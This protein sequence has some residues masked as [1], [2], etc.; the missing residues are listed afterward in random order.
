MRIFLGLDI[1]ASA[2]TELTKIARSW[3]TFKLVKPE[4]YHFT[5]VFLGDVSGD[6][7]SQITEISQSV[8]EKT[9]SF[10]ITLDTLVTKRD[11]LWAVPGRINPS[12]E[13]LGNTLEKQLVSAGVL[14]QPLHSFRPH[15]KL[16][17]TD[18]VGRRAST[19]INFEVAD[20]H[21]FESVFSE[22][23]GVSYNSL[24]KFEL[25]GQK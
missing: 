6:N 16:G 10:E 9:S 18:S 2:K 15:V 13:K 14:Q 5:L 24:Q 20:F 1:P 23:G 11:M 4:N 17:F 22:Q 19:E 25:T 7:I 3:D 8:A 21:M 12:L